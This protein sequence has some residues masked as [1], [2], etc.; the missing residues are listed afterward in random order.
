MVL[1]VSLLLV[2]P[3]FALDAPHAHAWM[4]ELMYL[5]MKSIPFQMGTANFNKTDCSGFVYLS[6]IHAGISVKRTTALDMFYGGGNWLANTVPVKDADCLDLIWF[7][8]EGREKDRPYGHVAIV[9]IPKSTGL[10]S[11]FGSWSKGTGVKKYEGKLIRDTSGIK[12]LTIG[13][14]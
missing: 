6:A 8:W 3:A 1:I 9:Y 14:Q 5:E 11:I 10:L 12:R 13:D 2:S 7:T 4:M